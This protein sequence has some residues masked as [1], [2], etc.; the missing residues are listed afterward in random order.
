L[1][2][3]S[4]VLPLRLRRWQK[5]QLFSNKTVL[6]NIMLEAAPSS[7]YMYGCNLGC[8]LSACMLT[9]LKNYTNRQ[10]DGWLSKQIR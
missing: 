4:I 5:S 8:S 7:V 2:N 9:Q 6:F 10:K 3:E 1:D